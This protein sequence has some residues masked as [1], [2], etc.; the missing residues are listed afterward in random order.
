MN[1]HKINLGGYN[2]KFIKNVPN[3]NDEELYIK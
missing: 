1:H 3:E 2:F